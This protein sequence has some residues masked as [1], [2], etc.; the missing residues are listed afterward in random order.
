[1]KEQKKIV[2]EEPFFLTF[3]RTVGDKI[4]W[5]IANHPEIYNYSAGLSGGRYVINFALGYVCEIWVCDWR[6]VGII[7]DLR[8]S[9]AVFDEKILPFFVKHLGNY[10]LET[11]QEQLSKKQEAEG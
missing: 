5:V 2:R 8:F 1:M 3:K 4:G 7:P 9:R 10:S 11:L 6:E